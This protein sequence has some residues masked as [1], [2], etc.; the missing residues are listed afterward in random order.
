VALALEQL[1]T[2]F[3]ATTYGL[4]IFFEEIEKRFLSITGPW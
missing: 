4:S 1:I 3:F 2:D